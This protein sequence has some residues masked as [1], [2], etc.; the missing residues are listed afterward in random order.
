[1]LL[2]P[3]PWC[4]PRDDAEFAY[5]NQAHVARPADPSAAADAEWA[6]YLYFSDNP[7]GPFAE[8]WMQAA[9]CR[10]WFNVERATDK[11]E[12]LGV[13]RSA[14]ATQDPAV[15]ERPRRRQACSDTGRGG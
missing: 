6:D 5:G 15:E 13:E 9:G 4:G 1:M 7:T 3:C 12:N 11:Q 8:R 14:E 2:I 10:R